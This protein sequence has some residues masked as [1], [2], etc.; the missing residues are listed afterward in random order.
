M[1]NL[2]SICGVRTASQMD[3]RLVPLGGYFLKKNPESEKNKV[4]GYILDYLEQTE[5]SGRYE[6]SKKIILNATYR[7][8]LPKMKFNL[9]FDEE[10]GLWIGEYSCE[11]FGKGD[12]K[13]KIAP[14]EEEVD[15]IS[16]LYRRN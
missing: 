14:L 12:V 13:L 10:K 5:I 1:N 4:S 6:H 2:F 7:R 9:N 11:M 16:N 3:N 8:F 15:F